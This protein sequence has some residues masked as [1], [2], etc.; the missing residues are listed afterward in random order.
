MDIFSN[1]IDFAGPYISTATKSL[2]QSPVTYRH[3]TEMRRG[4]SLSAIAFEFEKDIDG[5]DEVVC[6]TDTNAR[7]SV[8]VNNIA[9]FNVRAT[10]E[11]ELYKYAMDT[12]P[13][14]RITAAILISGKPLRDI[15]KTAG[16]G[17]NFASQMLRDEKPPKQQSLEALSIAVEVNPN[18]TMTG[19][20]KNPK[21]DRL[22][23]IFSETDIH[24]RQ[25]AFRTLSK[26]SD[27]SLSDLS[28]LCDSS[29][30]PLE[31]L[32]SWIA[33]AEHTFNSGKNTEAFTELAM[34]AHGKELD[35]DLLREA[36]EEAYE[37]EFAILGRLGPS[38][39]RAELVREIYDLRLN[40]Q[41]N[42]AQKK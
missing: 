19:N 36:L 26:G 38:K 30:V 5:I 41:N 28:D 34:I 40:K 35:L 17:V 29:N 25:K 37:V 24:T 12:R 9:R 21:I 3:P 10:L 33:N 20:P 23:E 27:L 11:K 42:S 15:S 16:L 22:L 2:I 7:I 6:H 1:S 14:D 4:H 31:A 18:W 39:K 8:H 32:Q 13:L